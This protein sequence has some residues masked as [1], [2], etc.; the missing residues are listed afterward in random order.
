MPDFDLVVIGAGASGLSVTGG[1]AQLGMRVASVERGTMGG[2]CLNTGCVPSKAL[3][4]AAHAAR[5]ICRT[6][7]FGTTA[8]EP[9]IAWDRQRDYVQSVIAEIAPVDSAE[10]F[11]G[12]GATAI[13]GEA[14]F[15]NSPHRVRWRKANHRK[16]VCHCRGKPC[17]SAR[18]SGPGSG[19]RIGTTDTLFDLTD[20]P[21]AMARQGL[22]RGGPA[23]A[24]EMKR[25]WRWVARGYAMKLLQAAPLEHWLW[26][27]DLPNLVIWQGMETAMRLVQPCTAQSAW[28]QSAATAGRPDRTASAEPPIRASADRVGDRC[29][30]RRGSAFR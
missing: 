5:T 23:G 15:L 21:D 24:R 30:H 11:R 17:R 29:V 6:A 19:C 16:A 1:A 10:R 12:L 18:H 27:W 26:G 9:A 2:D 13:L 22:V 3:L 4:A 8:Q 25:L 7:R 20:R 28:T 14:R